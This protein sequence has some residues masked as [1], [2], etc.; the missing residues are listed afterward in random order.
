MSDTM[1]TVTATSS[2]S[3]PAVDPGSDYNGFTNG[4]I[5]SLNGSAPVAPTGIGSVLASSVY[6]ASISDPNTGR[7]PASAA[8]GVIPLTG[9]GIPFRILTAGTPSEVLSQW[10]AIINYILGFDQ[11]VCNKI[12]LDLVLPGGSVIITDATTALNYL[13]R[14]AAIPPPV[15]TPLPV[16]PAPTD[17][18][19]VATAVNNYYL[20]KLGQNA[21]QA[22]LNYWTPIIANGSA[23]FAELQND[24]AYS[25]GAQ[26]AINNIWL[27]ETGSPIDAYSLGVWQ[28]NFANGQGLSDLQNDLAYSPYVANSINTV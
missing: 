28:Q 15:T 2:G 26:T 12:G 9:V 24:L 14:S 18:S 10:P 21:D 27:T 11:G 20:Q 6:D 16:Q 17:T 5:P 23:T 1:Y 8:V 7:L 13:Q 3:E 25:S 22:G 4:T 19:D